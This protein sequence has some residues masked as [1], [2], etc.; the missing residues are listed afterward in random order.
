MVYFWS[1]GNFFRYD[2][3]GNVLT[4]VKTSDG[5][6]LLGPSWMEKAGDHW[7]FGRRDQQ[8]RQRA[9]AD[10]RERDRRADAGARHRARAQRLLPR[11]AGRD[12]LD[13][14]LRRHRRRQAIRELWSTDGTAGARTASPTSTPARRASEFDTPNAQPT[15]VL[16]NGVLYFGRGTTF[17]TTACGAPTARPP[18]RTRSAGI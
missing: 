13:A 7:Y 10:G 9:V 16:S 18:A 12:R 1:A 14:V 2:P 3:A 6:A 15:T 5:T 11:A 4:Q 17:T 8:H